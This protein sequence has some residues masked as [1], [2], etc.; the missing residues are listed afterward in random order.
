MAVLVAGATIA[1]SVCKVA[2]EDGSTELANMAL[3]RQLGTASFGQRRAAAKELVE[4]GMAAKPALMQGMAQE[5]LEVRMAA[6]RILVQILQTEFDATINAFLSAQTAD[7]GAK[8]PGW[9]PFKANVGD[10]ANS[11][12]LFANMLR[13]EY[14]LIVAFD[15]DDRS[16]D[17]L[18][19]ERV[20]SIASTPMLANGSRSAIPAPTLATILFLNMHLQQVPQPETASANFNLLNAR[21][22]SILNQVAPRETL[23]REAHLPQIKQLM[24]NWIERIYNS[25]RQYGLR[26]A[27]KLILKYDL[28]DKGPPIA[29]KILENPGTNSSSV[30]NAVIVLGRF[31]TLEDIKRL[32]PHLESTQVFHTWSNPQLKK[33]PIRIQVR[34]AALAMTIRLHGEDP[35]A[36]GFKLLLP[37][38]QTVYKLYSLGFLEDAER[39]SAFANWKARVKVREAEQAAAQTDEAA[40]QGGGKSLHAPPG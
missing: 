28:R 1:V 8:V 14:Q 22:L 35:E 18:L 38:E 27:I 19:L 23:L 11:R 34:D 31:G 33:E 7:T 36:Y 37:D 13:A 2:A 24:G 21:V 29:R 4:L 16:L 26:N 6:H 39:D 32:E 30:P 15:Q 10:S 9:E 25:R 12:Q 3:V 5:D 20:K 17:Q 40:G